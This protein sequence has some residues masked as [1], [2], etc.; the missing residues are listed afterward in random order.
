MKTPITL[1]LFAIA[2]ISLISGT[3]LVQ[4]KKSHA[5]V[6][7]EY[8]HSFDSA[9][10]DWQ[11]IQTFYRSFSSD[12]IDIPINTSLAH[13]FG[14]FHKMD[15]TLYNATSVDQLGH[16]INR[17]DG[18]F[19]IFTQDQQVTF[20][21]FE[22]FSDCRL[23]EQDMLIYLTIEGGTGKY[24]NA[25]G[26]IKLKYDGSIFTFDKHVLEVDGEIRI[27]DNIESPDLAHL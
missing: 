10:N 20:G 4:L 6:E 16:L 19:T 27:Y 14:E 15:F 5:T 2:T 8:E 21:R 24:K 25:A 18:F 13:C 11:Q 9:S 3:Y 23:D 7:L 17:G 12:V 22:S 26:F 1:S